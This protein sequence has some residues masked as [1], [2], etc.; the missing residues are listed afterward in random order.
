MKRGRAF[1]EQDVEEI[2]SYC[3]EHLAGARVSPMLIDHGAMLG[4]HI[5][6][7][8]GHMYILT[9]V[10]GDTGAGIVKALLDRQKAM[11]R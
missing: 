3:R 9:A 8:D 10:P 5:E 1:T 4:L 6:T 11:E 2:V 7:P